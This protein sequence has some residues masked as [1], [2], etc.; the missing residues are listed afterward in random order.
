MPTTEAEA[1][2]EFADRT[3]GEAL[4]RASAWNAASLILPQLYLVAT[5][6]IVA[7]F[8]TPSEMGRQSYIAFIEL[9]LLLLVTGGVP[10]AVQRFGGRA[11]GRGEPGNVPYLVRWAARLAAVGAFIAG[12]AM[13]AA[14]LLGSEPRAAWILAGGFCFVGVLQTVPA[15]ALAVLQRW[16]GVSIAG[17][18]FGAVS[19]VGV[20][21]VLAAG[22][23]I[24]GFFAVE[25]AVAAVILL[26]TAWLGRSALRR[27][28][29]EPAKSTELRREARRWAL[30]ATF[31][32]ILTFVVWRRSEFLF[33]NQYSS[34]E[35]IAVY[36]IAFASIVAVTKLPEAVGTV[37]SPAFATLSGAGQTDRIS[38]G[39]A[40]AMRLLLM[41]SLPL[42]ALVMAIGPTAIRLVYGTSYK[43]A[44]KLLVIMAPTLPVLSLVSVSRGLVFGVGRQR[45]LVMVGMFA[46]VVNVALD[47]VLIRLFNATG[48]AIANAAAQSAAAVAYVLMARRSAGPVE[49]ALGALVR[50]ALAAAAAGVA[51]WAVTEAL[52]GVAGAFAGLA[53]FAVGFAV[54]AVVLRVMPSQDAPWLDAVAGARLR[55]RP[56]VEAQRIISAAS[57]AG[58]RSRRCAS[59]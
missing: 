37:I 47:V 42:T 56:R 58:T 41:V 49:W 33:L 5:S 21:A 15:S 26:V 31:T 29:A 28:G 38:S 9:S 16:R 48:A 8:L 53:V 44:G 35:Q 2:S 54:L 39:Y 59:R 50:N 23:G 57:G 51:A 45:S 46:A 43:E 55:G 24:T 27:L 7:R 18:S 1:R 10:S 40:R 32:S 22:G 19:T 13:V 17:I 14:G 30:I 25:F 20:L 6:I 36:S 3:T 34:D 4:L 12:G 11:L 52:G